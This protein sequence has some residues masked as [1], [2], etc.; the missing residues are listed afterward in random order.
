M[1][2]FKINDFEGPLDLL[3]HLIKES[4]M[5]IMNIEIVELTNQYVNFLQEM[6]ELSLNVASEYLIMAAELIHL[7]SKL[8]LPTL[9]EEDE[10][11][12][13]IEKEK[14]VNRLLEYERYKDLVSDFKELEEKRKEV[15][16]KVPSNLKE[17]KSGEIHLSQEV[18]LNDLLQAFQKF[19]EARA[20]QEPISTKVTKKEYTVEERISSIRMLFK[21]K[22]KV[23]FTEL[24]DDFS[25]SYVIV[26]FLSILEMAKTKELLI[27]QENNFDKIYLEVII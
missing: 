16:T 26:T 21:D 23:E 15:F 24:F 10:E 19:L 13:E 17:Y 2:N 14:L 5:D 12:I 8:L 7:K 27:T 6:E 25:K 20:M 18:S 4:K 9:I 3:L 11:E 22:D 1:Y